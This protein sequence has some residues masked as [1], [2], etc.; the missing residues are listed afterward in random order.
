MRQDAIR[1]LE[2]ADDE[3]LI[4]AASHGELE[5]QVIRGKQAQAAAPEPAHELRA[6]SLAEAAPR[7]GLARHAR[8]EF[9]DR[10]AKG[11]SHRDGTPR[12]VQVGPSSVKGT[13]RSFL[14]A[15]QKGSSGPTLERR[16]LMPTQRA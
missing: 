7:A 3:A 12:I 16:S 9:A 8:A 4:R 6:V 5:A 10:R 13:P 14:T 11:H 1:A 2:I 15:S